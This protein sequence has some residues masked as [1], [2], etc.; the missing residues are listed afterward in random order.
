MS[1]LGDIMGL[2]RRHLYVPDGVPKEPRGDLRDAGIAKRWIAKRG[3]AEVATAIVGFAHLRDSGALESWCP[4]GTKVS[5]RA[6]AVNQNGGVRFYELC[7]SAGFRAAY[8]K[9]GE[10]MAS[11]GSI[12]KR[13]LK[14]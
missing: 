14:A 7:V 2:I 6:L 8:P 13:A 4:P 10:G 12:M 3:A 5:L 11:L 1:E 9:K